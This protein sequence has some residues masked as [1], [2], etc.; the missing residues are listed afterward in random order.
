MTALLLA[1]L[2]A[3]PPATPL[4]LQL[5]R[6]SR[7]AERCAWVEEALY[8]LDKAETAIAV[9]TTK[10]QRRRAWVAWLEARNDLRAARR[11]RHIH[12]E[13]ARRP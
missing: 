1:A 8:R 13:Q 5:E 10:K 12:Q 4:E 11:A 2:L 7:Y 6:V 9:A 3:S